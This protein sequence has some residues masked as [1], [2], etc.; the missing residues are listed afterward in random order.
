ML[1]EKISYYKNGVTTPW[2]VGQSSAVTVYA[3]KRSRK[4]PPRE[5]IKVVAAR[6][7]CSPAVYWREFCEIICAHEATLDMIESLSLYI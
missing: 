2:W 3:V 6:A 5:P 7:G 1:K 4:R